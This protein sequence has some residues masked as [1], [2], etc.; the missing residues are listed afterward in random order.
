MIS[1][2]DYEC[3]SRPPAQNFSF[4]L[5]QSQFSVRM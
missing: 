1:D 4:L 3:Y 5:I 2:D